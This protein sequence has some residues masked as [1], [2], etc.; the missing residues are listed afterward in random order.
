MM[1]RYTGFFVAILVAAALVFGGRTAVT[2][3]GGPGGAGTGAPGSDP[4]E[5]IEIIQAAFEDLDQQLGAAYG[6]E[7]TVYRWLDDTFLNTDLNCRAPGKVLPRER[8]RGFSIWIRVIVRG[9]FTSF[10]Y[11]STRDGTVLFQC[12]SKGPGPLI[13]VPDAPITDDVYNQRIQDLLDG[14]ANSEPTPTP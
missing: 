5:P 2:A 12:T 8:V 4:K 14:T 3:D 1:R 10:I 6:P 11:R 13:K 7:T 9:R